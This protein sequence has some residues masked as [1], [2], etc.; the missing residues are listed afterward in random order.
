M[1]KTL[2]RAFPPNFQKV[3]DYIQQEKGVDVK[4]GGTTVYLGMT[5]KRIFVDYRYNLEKNGLY[6]LLHEVGHALQPETNT[7]ANFY[8]S[9]DDDKQPKKF[10]MYQFLNEVDAWDRGY[11][12]A[13]ELGIEIN[14]TEWNKEKEEALLTYFV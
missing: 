14:D 4:L 10:G 3:V 9:I 12:L 7:G 8:K 5:L 2:D 1:R 6:A 11:Q 13:E